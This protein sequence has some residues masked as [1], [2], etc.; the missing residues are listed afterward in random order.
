MCLR[1]V[2]GLGMGPESPEFKLPLYSQPSAFEKEKLP[3]REACVASQCSQ[4]SSEAGTHRGDGSHLGDQPSSELWEQRQ[5]HFNPAGT[6]SRI[7]KLPDCSEGDGN[8]SSSRLLVLLVLRAVCSVHQALARRAGPSKVSSGDAR[9]EGMSACQTDSTLGCRTKPAKDTQWCSCLGLVLG[10]WQ[11]RS[12][13]GWVSCP[14]SVVKTQEV[15]S[16]V[17]GDF[18][19]R[20]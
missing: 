20:G 15:L 11:G 17:Q 18:A 10:H 12:P 13:T 9:S 1:S 3:S 7:P 14:P 8:S 2:S 4:S 6:K 5:L 16:P 19:H